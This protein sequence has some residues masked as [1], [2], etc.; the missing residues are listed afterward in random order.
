MRVYVFVAIFLHGVGFC[1]AVRLGERAC[2]GLDTNGRDP[3]CTPAYKAY[4]ISN[5]ALRHNVA[6]VENMTYVDGKEKEARMQDLEFLKD[7]KMSGIFSVKLQKIQT[8]LNGPLI[9]NSALIFNHNKWLDVNHRLYSK[10]HEILAHNSPIEF[11]K[12]IDK[13]FELAITHKEVYQELGIS[14]DGFDQALFSALYAVSEEMTK[15][16]PVSL[17]MILLENLRVKPEFQSLAEKFERIILSGAGSKPLVFKAWIKNPNSVKDVRRILFGTKERIGL[18]DSNFWVW[19]D[20]LHFVWNYSVT[21]SKPNYFEFIDFLLHNGLTESEDMTK[22]L[23]NPE[24]SLRFPHHSADY[25]IMRRAWYSVK[26]LNEGKV[27][28]VALK[29]IN[30][31]Q[32]SASDADELISLLIYAFRYRK[33]FQYFDI[34]LYRFLTSNRPFDQVMG[35]LK[36]SENLPE[37]ISEMACNMLYSMITDK[38]VVTALKNA[39]TTFEQYK[40]YFADLKAVYPKSKPTK[41]AT[42]QSLVI[43]D[44]DF[45]ARLYVVING[46]V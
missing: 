12:I 2:H 13:W 6:L 44:D 42:S 46:A 11:D 29:E 43:P 39:R 35:L 10:L 20:Y 7:L 28:A 8:D 22:V 27:P 16:V 21:V 15:S 24:F 36:S 23:D 31:Y 19:F 37:S 3:L 4:T 34:D 33:Q 9:I 30:D 38:A 17:M 5:R 41:V 40:Q 1:F 25:K 18:D 32:K 26:C 14:S 45:W